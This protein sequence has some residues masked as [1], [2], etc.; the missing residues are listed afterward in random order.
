MNILAI[1]HHSGFA[2]RVPPVLGIVRHW[3]NMR[4]PVRRAGR[5]CILLHARTPGTCMQAC[6]HA[7]AVG[8]D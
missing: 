7:N 3:G 6:M 5:R 2:D 8:D 1:L 4:D